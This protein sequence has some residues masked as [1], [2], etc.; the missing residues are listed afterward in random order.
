MGSMIS[1]I[2]WKD[3]PLSGLLNQ[4]TARL[5]LGWKTQ[6]NSVIIFYTDTRVFHLYAIPG[7]AKMTSTVKSGADSSDSGSQAAGSF[8]SEGSSQRSEENTSELQSIMRISYA[9]FCLKNKT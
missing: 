8:S 9:V 1:G 2:N 7:D 3:K 6:D 5:G 4:V